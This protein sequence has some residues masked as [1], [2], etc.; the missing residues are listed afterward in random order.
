MKRKYYNPTYVKKLLRRYYEQ[1]CPQI[2]QIDE[3]NKF[4][5]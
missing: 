4:L 2:Q 3:M 1:L 5:E